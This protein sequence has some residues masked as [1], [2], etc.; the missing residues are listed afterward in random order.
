MFSSFSLFKHP[1]SSK[2]SEEI[3]IFPYV[4]LVW[5]DHHHDL[6]QTGAWDTYLEKT[7]IVSRHI[8]CH[9]NDQ[10]KRESGFK[11]SKEVRLGNT[12]Q[13]I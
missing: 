13:N 5:E 10:Q 7:H 11:L 1:E 2:I 12:C 9:S 3:F 4:T 8:N 6:P